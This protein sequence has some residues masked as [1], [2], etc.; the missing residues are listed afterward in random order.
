[1]V[2]VNALANILPIN[3]VTTGEL[4]DAYPSLFTPAGYVFGIWGLIYLLLVI[5]VVYQARDAQQ[6]NLRLDA[7]GYA[8]VVSCVFN[9]GWIFAWHYG[10]ILLS[11]LFML[12]ILASLVV[13]YERLKVGA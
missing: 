9:I 8:F 5:F 7:L 1:M 10:Q 11:T 4:S 3:G 6:H 12:G 13:C 2:T